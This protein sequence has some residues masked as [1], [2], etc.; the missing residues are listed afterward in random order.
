MEMW[1]RVEPC[2]ERWRIGSLTVSVV[3]WM[4]FFIRQASSSS[5]HVGQFDCTSLYSFPYDG[6][7]YVGTRDRLPLSSSIV[8]GSVSSADRSQNK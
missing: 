6:T 8:E 7:I 1:E 3:V 4:P 5:H 2:F